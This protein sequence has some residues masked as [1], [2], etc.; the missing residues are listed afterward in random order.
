MVVKIEY[1]K[2]LDEM[3]SR[4]QKLIQIPST[5]DENTVSVDAPYGEKVKA[6]LDYMCKLAKEDG[7][8]VT[9]YDNQA[10]SLSLG[11]REERIDIVSHL[12]VVDPGNNWADD[13]FSGKIVDGKMYGR[14]TQ[15]M[16]MSVLI[17]YTALKMIKEYNIDCKREIRLV[18]GT[19][20]ERTMNDMEHYVSIANHPDFAFTPDGL[21]PMSIGE[22][23]ALRWLIEGSVA[24]VVD[25]LDA[26][27]QCNVIPPFGTAKLNTN[28]V[29]KVNELIANSNI[30]AKCWLENN[31][32]VIEVE[33]K[34]AHA[35]R[36][37]HGHSAANDLLYLIKEAT[38]DKIC[39]NLHDMFYDH[40][41]VGSKIDADIEPMG[42]LT[43]S[44]GVIRVSEGNVYVEVDGR[45]PLGVTS[46]EMTEKLN[47]L[48]FLP[49]E[50]T[51]DSVPILAD[52]NSPYIQSLLNTYRKHTADYREPV[53]SGGVSYSKVVNNCVAFGPEM[54]L[55]HQAN[56][57][58]DLGYME[59]MLKMYTE[60][61]IEVS[62]I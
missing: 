42:K 31:Q 34:A 47:D 23:G 21:F 19:D 41:G 11:K 39:S 8:E 13:P 57:C 28:C 5:Y 9:N 1:E 22:K 49:V 44:I 30:N 38:S 46:K 18:F 55:A 2:Y 17:T 29:D 20:E 10:I 35:S 4:L 7:I 25:T 59:K 61:M 43:C 6:A 53:I 62:N 58:I 40:Y 32:T 24:T 60:A 15:D 14:G 56:E 33:G 16:K 36:P 50:L 48:C 27:V 12:D 3:T 52:I 45:Y 37:D 26:G 54:P 51:H